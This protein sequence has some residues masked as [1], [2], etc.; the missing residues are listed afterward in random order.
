[1]GLSEE[2]VQRKE[3]KSGSADM[4]AFRRR[5]GVPKPSLDNAEGPGTPR[6]QQMMEAGTDEP[7]TTAPATTTTTTTRTTMGTSAKA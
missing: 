3:E 5:Q 4:D 6:E 7:T 1:M 2:T